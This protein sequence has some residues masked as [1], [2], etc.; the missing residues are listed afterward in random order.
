MPVFVLATNQVSAA[1]IVTA[2]TMTMTELRR[3]GMPRIVQE[4]PRL[5]GVGYPRSWSPKKPRAV[6]WR[7][8][9]APIAVMSGTRRGALRSGRYA[10]RSSNTATATEHTMPAIIRIAMESTGLEL[11]KPWSFSTLATKYEPNAPN[12]NTSPWAKL[13]IRRTP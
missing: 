4:P 2:T 5:S 3:M 8:S 1:T 12:M 6:F 9:E 10:T 11:I 7:N 13:I